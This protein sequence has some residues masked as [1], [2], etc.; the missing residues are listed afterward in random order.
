MK[1]E[2]KMKTKKVL[3][4]VSLGVGSAVEA[5]VG[6]AGTVVGSMAVKCGMEQ[7][8]DGKIG[9][10]ITNLV[11]GAVSMGFGAISLYDGCKTAHDVIK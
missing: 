3:Q 7:M 5:S 9:T 4:K 6:A 10:G 1:F 11:L 2:T 8:E